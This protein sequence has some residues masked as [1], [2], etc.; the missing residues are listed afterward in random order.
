MSTTQ[1]SS[2]GSS[3]RIGHNSEKFYNT[4][5]YQNMNI[6]ISNDKI[7]NK[8]KDENLNQIFAHSCE[9]MHELPDSSVHLVITSPPYNVSKDYD[10]NLSLKEYMELL[11]I[12]FNECFRVLVDGG[13]ACINIANV[14]RKPYIPLTFYVYQIMFEIG[15]LSRG[16]IIWDKGASSGVSL[17]WGSFK[18]ASN[19]VLRDVHEYILVFSKNDFKRDKNKKNDSISKENFM[20]Y[21][22]SIWQFSTASAKKI[23]HP[24]PFP[25]E[26]PNR[27][28]ELYSFENDIVLDPFMGSG[29]TAISAYNLKRNFVGYEINEE[30]IKIAQN[31]LNDAK[32]SLFI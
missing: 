23:G 19:P 2:F 31:R 24:A 15:F 3:G 17:A 9:N 26:L 11:K 8:I 5:L 27:L 30:Y 28:I 29:T 4:R 20:S 13:R 1:T 10:E 7:E 21:T 14:G 32:N 16:E 6:K 25:V 18:S 22:K 12:V